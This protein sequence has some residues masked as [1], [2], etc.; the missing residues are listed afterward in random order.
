[1]IFLYEIIPCILLGLY[2]TL[3]IRGRPQL[4]ERRNVGIFFCLFFYIDYG[5]M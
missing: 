2:P 3:T 4:P 1:M 5:R